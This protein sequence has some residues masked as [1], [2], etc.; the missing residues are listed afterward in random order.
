MAITNGY[1]TLDEFKDWIAMRGLSG[2]VTTDASDDA[3]LEIE[4]EAASRYID[5]ETGKRF[6]KDSSDATRYYTADNQSLLK[7]DPLAAAPTSV[8][9]DY[10]EGLR[11][12]TDLTSTQYDLMPLNATLEGQPYTYIEINPAYGG[13]FPLTNKGV[14]VV[15]LFGYPSVPLDVRNATLAIVQNLNSARSGQSSAGRVTVTAAGVVI[16]P[17]DV[18]PYAMRVIEHYRMYT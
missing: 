15:G 16:R 4:I 8:S 11:S 10:T 1:A 7:I 2:T 18:P 17:E 5:R 6:F 3:L 14:K 12:Y 13:Y 9:V